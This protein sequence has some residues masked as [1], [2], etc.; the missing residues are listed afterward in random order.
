[1]TVEQAHLT[2]E[3]RRERVVDNSWKCLL[4]IVRYVVHVFRT[5]QLTW[6]R[7]Q[8]TIHESGF[9]FGAYRMR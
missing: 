5:K 9:E 4:S 6:Q 8:N 3:G 1:M 7:I 2:T